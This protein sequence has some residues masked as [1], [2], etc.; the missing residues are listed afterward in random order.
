MPSTETSGW[1]PDTVHPSST[2]PRCSAAWMPV[3]QRRR[4]RGPAPSSRWRIQVSDGARPTPKSERRFRAI[5]GSP[6]PRTCRPDCSS[7]GV[8]DA[9]TARPDIRQSERLMPRVSTG[10]AMR[11]RH[12]RTAGGMP[13]IDR[14]FRKE[15]LDIF[16]LGF[17]LFCSGMADPARKVHEKKFATPAQQTDNERKEFLTGIAAGGLIAGSPDSGGIRAAA[18]T[19]RPVR[20][21]KD[22]DSGGLGVGA[23]GRGGVRARILGRQAPGSVRSRYVAGGSPMPRS[24]SKEVRRWRRRF[25]RKTDPSRWRWARF[26]RSPWY[27]PMAQRLRSGNTRWIHLR[28]SYVQRIRNERR[29]WLWKNLARFPVENMPVAFRRPSGSFLWRDRRR[30][31]LPAAAV[32]GPAPQDGLDRLDP[33]SRQRIRPGAWSARPPVHL[34]GPGWMPGFSEPDHREDRS[35]RA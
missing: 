6:P 23:A 17:C 10:S 14:C 1:P 5:T 25:H 18:A 3:K 13:G 7:D 33:G 11:W 12:A 24:L 27:T 29:R 19:R 8:L 35:G 28:T 16:L 20:S 22:R 26:L 34:P 9:N 32:R 4:S 21:R 15:S 2:F 30:R 31:S